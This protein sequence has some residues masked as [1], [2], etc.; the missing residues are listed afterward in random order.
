MTSP[1][2]TDPPYLIR[3]AP[4]ARG[5]LNR[6]KDIM[7]AGQE[8]ESADR[9]DLGLGLLDYDPRENRLRYPNGVSVFAANSVDAMTPCHG[10]AVVAATI[11]GADYE[12]SAVPLPAKK[13]RSM[14]RRKGITVFIPRGA[15]LLRQVEIKHTPD[16]CAFGPARARHH[17]LIPATGDLGSWVDQV[18]RCIVTALLSSPPQGRW[19]HVQFPT[20]LTASPQA[21]SFAD[22]V[23]LAWNECVR[24]YG[25]PPPELSGASGW[26]CDSVQLARFERMR[27]DMQQ[28]LAHLEDPQHS[29]PTST[30]R[31]PPSGGG[32]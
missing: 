23:L 13:L 5:V 21:V 1:A 28:S 19:F 17:D 25:E 26:P 2:R 10:L 32:E 9:E 8:V 6:L 16:A 15:L 7:R 27:H 30:Q 11:D 20:D 22:L 18:T 12:P 3:W 4:K 24:Q 29:S 31:Q 14:G